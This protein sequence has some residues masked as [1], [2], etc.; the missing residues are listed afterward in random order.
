M[1]GYEPRKPNKWGRRGEEYQRRTQ[2]LIGPRER[3][4]AAQL[5]KTGKIFS[6]ACR[7]R[8]MRQCGRRGWRHSGWPTMTGSNAVTGSPANAAVPG[9]QWSEDI[10]TVPTHGSTHWEG[11]AATPCSAIRFTTASGPGT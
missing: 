2:N 8:P 4:A 1:G 5:V 6:L 11:L 9:F 3:V 10:L 7:S